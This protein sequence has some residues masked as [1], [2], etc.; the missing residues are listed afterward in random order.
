MLPLLQVLRLLQVSHR[1]DFLKSPE[2]GSHTGLCSVLFRESKGSQNV[3]GS[4]IVT[5]HP[6][7]LSS[8]RFFPSCFFMSSAAFSLRVLPFISMMLSSFSFFGWRCGFLLPL[9]VV[10]PSFPSILGGGAFSLCLLGGGAVLP[11]VKSVLL[12]LQQFNMETRMLRKFW[13]ISRSC[14]VPVVRLCQSLSHP[15]PPVF[16]DVGVPWVLTRTH[17]RDAPSRQDDGVIR[18]STLWGWCCHGRHVAMDISDMCYL[19]TVQLCKY[20]V[21]FGEPDPNSAN[22]SKKY[23]APINV[24]QIHRLKKKNVIHFDCEIVW[25]NKLN[26]I[27]YSCVQK[28]VG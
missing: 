23:Q 15:R 20:L 7:P 25:W 12:L 28:N 9:L 8:P 1:V 18:A 21:L 24:W 19:P 17:Q 4:G 14:R 22:R 26:F 13:S 10:L 16:D 2:F 3:A 5:L 11:C 27:D 6:E